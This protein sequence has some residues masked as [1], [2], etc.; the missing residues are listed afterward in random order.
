M[1]SARAGLAWMSS[2]FCLNEG[3]GQVFCG[4]WVGGEFSE[5][6]GIGEELSKA[7]AVA[8]GP[9]RVVCCMKGRV[10]EGVNDGFRVRFSSQTFCILDLF[11][12]FPQS[13]TVLQFKTLLVRSDS[14]IELS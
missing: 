10:S 6:V 13:R 7:K 11:Q 12:S 1:V 5:K 9:G 3:I 8:T 2:S 4:S 14:F